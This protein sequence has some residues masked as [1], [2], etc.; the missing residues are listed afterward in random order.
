MVSLRLFLVALLAGC[1]IQFAS[2]IPPIPWPTPEGQ[3]FGEVAPVGTALPMAPLET[4]VPSL[5]IGELTS[6]D[7]IELCQ[8]MEYF[9][10]EDVG[11]CLT[12]GGESYYVWIEPGRVLEVA[13]NNPY[14]SE[15]RTASSLR[16]SAIGARDDARRSLTKLLLLPFEI[17]GLAACGVAIVPGPQQLIAI[18]VCAGDLIAIGFTA[19]D[20]AR[21]GEDLANAVIEEQNQFKDAAYNLCRMEGYSDAE[22]R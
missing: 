12:L 7:A 11:T 19:D 6:A 14:F 13:R 1:D 21:D 15:F 16:K 3:P 9:G 5:V 17:L 10:N 2:D 18:T 4:S 20:L 22:C 8:G